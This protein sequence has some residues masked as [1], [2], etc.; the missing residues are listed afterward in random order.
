MNGDEMNLT[1]EYMKTK[2]TQILMSR[3]AH[4]VSGVVV[5]VIYGLF[6]YAHY[7]TFIKTDQF[8]WL[9]LCF[10]ETLIVGMYIFRR[11]P[12]TIS[13]DVFDWVIAMI[14]SF[15]P[16]FFRPSTWGVFPIAEYLIMLGIVL[17][18]LGLISLNS[19]FALVAANRQVKTHWMYQ[20][21]RHP[22]YASY[23]LILI[24]YVLVNTTMFNSF[25]YLL[26]MT[27]LGL[28]IIKEE[29]HLMLDPLYRQYTKKVRYRLIPYII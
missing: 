28:R 9:M 19:S 29:K 1:K 27:F 20:V 17:Q 11:K 22:I 23:C 6:I 21:V 4:I 8:V 25:I 10:S 24:G 13:I 12:Q 15:A 26:S 16:L 2:I 7:L 5:C 14:G 3:V 18:V